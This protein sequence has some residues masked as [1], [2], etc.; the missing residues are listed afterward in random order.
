MTSFICVLLT[1]SM[2]FSL[3]KQGTFLER[4]RASQMRLSS[5]SLLQ[6]IF[7]GSSS[8]VHNNALFTPKKQLNTACSPAKKLT[9]S[10]TSSIGGKVREFYIFDK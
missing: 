3:L 6:R 2:C 1:N 10:T 8:A 9:P 5:S 4:S 7:G